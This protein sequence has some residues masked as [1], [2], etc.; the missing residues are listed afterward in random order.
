MRCREAVRKYQE[1]NPKKKKK[2]ETSQQQQKKKK[3]PAK[4]E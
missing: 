3:K 4:N 1:Y 2:K